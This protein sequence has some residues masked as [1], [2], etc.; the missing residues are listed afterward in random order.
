MKYNSWEIASLLIP[1]NVKKLKI[2]LLPTETKESRQQSTSYFVLSDKCQ[3]IW[4]VSLLIY[5]C[6]CKL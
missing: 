4:I 6:S 3:P 2:I 1:W 5:C